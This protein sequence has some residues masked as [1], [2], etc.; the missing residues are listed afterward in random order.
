MKRGWLFLLAV[1]CGIVLIVLVGAVL[2]PVVAAVLIV[3]SL[4]ALFVPRRS[5]AA[6]DDDV[7]EPEDDIPAS[8]AVIDVQAVDV[9]D[10][11]PEKKDE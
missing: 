2:L 4:L 5:G 6:A 9:T 11:E 7:P 3:W 1:I 8:Q 10:A